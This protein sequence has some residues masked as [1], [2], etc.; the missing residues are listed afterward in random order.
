METGNITVNGATYTCPFAHVLPPLATEERAELESDIRT[1]GITVPVLVTDEN[2]VIDGHNRLQIAVALGLTE[3]PVVV[4][5]GLTAVQKHDRA[6]ALNLRRRHLT[7]EQRREIV[8]RRLKADP[9]LSNNAIAAALNVD[10]KT[11]ASVRRDLEATSEIPKTPARRGTDGRS[12][13]SQSVSRPRR[14]PVRPAAKTDTG[15]PAQRPACWSDLKHIAAELQEHIRDLSRGSRAKY[16]DPGVVRAVAERLYREV[17]KL[18]R[19]V[20][21]MTAPVT[22]EPAEA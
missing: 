13:R 20:D 7:R 22:P 14:E 18:R 17:D 16:R 2:E 11:V 1:H 3:V 5:S 15:K 12:R 10:D 9:A 4:V 6:V 8:A 19:W 21:E